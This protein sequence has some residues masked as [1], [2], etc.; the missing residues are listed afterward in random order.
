MTEP[1]V[2]TRV[3]DLLR[4]G[5][6]ERRLA[7]LALDEHLADERLDEREYQRRLGACQEAR[8]RAELREVFADLPPPHP[9]LL[10]S[11]DELD[12]NADLPAIA[13]AG[14]GTLLLGLP[15]A[16]V[17]GIVYDAWWVLAVPVGVVIALLIVNYLLDRAAARTP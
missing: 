11:P 1:P 5:A 12:E 13:I 16:V 17:Y 4:I 10:D 8:N 2:D 15:V 14:C 3:A 9:A 6:P 7:R